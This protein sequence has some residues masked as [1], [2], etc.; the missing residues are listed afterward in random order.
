MLAPVSG[1]IT[2]FGVSGNIILK[3]MAHARHLA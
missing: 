2:V 1:D 3:T